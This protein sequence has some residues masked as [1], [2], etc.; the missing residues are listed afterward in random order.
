[1]TSE[2]FLNKKWLAGGPILFMLCLFLAVAG[3]VGQAVVLGAIGAWIVLL[4]LIGTRIRPS[5]VVYVLHAGLF[6]LFPRTIPIA[7]ITE[8]SVRDL[9]STFGWRAVKIYGV[10]IAAARN[11]H[12]ILFDRLETRNRFVAVLSARLT[13][14]RRK[15]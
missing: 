5:T 15:S 8:I 6:P 9:D 14:A 10:D 3:G 11:T 7:D 2:T 12:R 13:P 1:M 4:E